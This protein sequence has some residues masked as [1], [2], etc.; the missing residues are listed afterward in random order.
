MNQP[1]MSELYD[2]DIE[3]VDLVGSAANGHRFLMA[4]NAAGM[5]TP[6]AIRQ[7]LKDAGDDAAAEATN[8][9]PITPPP[10]IAKESAMADNTTAAD[11][12]AVTKE[13]PEDTNPE[14]DLTKDSETAADAAAV[15]KA[16]SMTAVFDRNGNLV[17]VVAP[18]AITP[19]DG[20]DAPDADGDSDGDM[21]DVD[22]SAA[23]S[24]TEADGA[25]QIDGAGYGDD[26]RQIP[27]T[28]TVQSPVQKVGEDKPKKGKK[29]NVTKTTAAETDFAAVLKEAL[30]PFVKQIQDL[31]DANEVLK[32]RVEKFGAQPDNRAIP[33]FNGA[34][35]ANAGVS[36]RDTSTDTIEPL[37]KAL[38]DAKASGDLTKIQKA[39]TE[40][41]HQSVLERFTR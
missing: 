16:D 4:K 37:K 21:Q 31:T 1:D 8:A 39:N 12:E 41:L 27:G 34:N 28:D 29:K 32:E 14:T 9:D 13:A 10:T 35:G 30:A 38:E 11:S 22:A 3:R 2:A 15:A 33:S 5:V 19:V 17:G 36:P 26:S 18:D 25:S 7:L 24:Q 40:L 6:D 20:G 23:V